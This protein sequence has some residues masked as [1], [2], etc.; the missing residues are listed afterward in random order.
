MKAFVTGGVRL[1]SS[2]VVGIKKGTG[3]FY[4]LMNQRVEK[5]TGYFY[6]FMKKT[7]QATLTFTAGNP[8]EKVACPL[9]PSDKV[10]CPLFSWAAVGLA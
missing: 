10:A 3:Y 5:G 4:L 2:A 7:E 9:F 6:V 1:L 8:P